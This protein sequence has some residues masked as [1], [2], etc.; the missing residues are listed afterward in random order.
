MK[1]IILLLSLLIYFSCFAL[2]ST[3]FAISDLQYD[4]SLNWQVLESP[5]FSVYFPQNRNTTPDLEPIA[6]NIAEIAEEIRTKVANQLGISKHHHFQKTAIIIEDFSDY[7]QGF[8]STFPHRVIR[9]SLTAPNAKS[10]DMKFKSWLKMVIAHEYTHIAHYEM[11]GG[12]TRPLRA[13]FGQI[14]TPN[15][16]QPIWSIEGL[17]VYNETSFSSGGRGVDTRYDMY[18]RMDSLENDFLS[19]D[20]ISGYYLKSWPSGT[21][22]YIYGQSLIH[23]ISENYGEDKIIKLSENFIR[24]PLLG[25]NHATKKT[26]NIDLNELYQRWKDDLQIKFAKQKEKII[27]SG[28]ITKSRQLT[29]YSY[30]VDYPQWF[31]SQAKD[32][33]IFRASTPH[34]YP[35]IQTIDP[36]RDFAPL[37]RSVIEN[38]SL[39]KRTYGRGSS[40]DISNNFPNY[41]VYSKINNDNRYYEFFDLYLYQFNTGEEFQL[42]KGLRARDPVFSPSFN[43]KGKGGQMAAIIN[44][45]GTNNLILVDLDLPQILNRKTRKIEKTDSNNI[46]YLT[47]FEDGTQLYE[48]SWSPDGKIIALS[49]WK[50]GALDIY[51]LNLDLCA[52]FT[53][54]FSTFAIFHDRYNDLSPSWS[55]D[56]EYLF[57]SSDRTGIYNIFA[58][59][60]SNRKLYQVTNVLGGA[61][62][63]SPSPDNKQLAYIEYHATGYELHLMEIN[64]NLW[65]EIKYDSYQPNQSNQNFKKK[66]GLPLIK[67]PVDSYHALSSLWPP[68]YWIPAVQISNNSFNLGFSTELKDVLGI[69]SIPFMFTYDIFNRNFNYSLNYYSYE[70]NP[71]VHFYWSGKTSALPQESISTHSQISLWD[72][73]ITGFNVNFLSRGNTQLTKHSRSYRQKFSLGYQYEKLPDNHSFDFNTIPNSGPDNN[74]KDNIASLRLKYTYSD[75]EKYSFSVSPEYGQAFSINYEH[76]DPA[77]GG[78]YAFDKLL[79]DGRKYISLKP[80]HHVLAL[81]LVAGQ[82]SNNILEKEKFNLGGHV[83]GDQFANIDL[84]SYSLRGYSP[85]FIKGSH[86]LFASMEYRFPITTIERGLKTGP[87]FLFL[88]KISGLLFFDIG[89]VWD[90]ASSLNISE[91]NAL[92]NHWSDF[93]SGIGL[94]LKAEFNQKFEFPF[95]LRFGAAKALSSS[96]GYDI[97]FSLDSSF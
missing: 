11:T 45:S 40:Y 17:A 50:N 9:L 27:A 52:N 3:S 39:I 5:H 33:I 1:K 8:A 61:F 19:L 34:S 77:L 22:P 58:F 38:K 43:E 51:T 53:K 65:K 21:A 25:M 47:Q 54:D 26:L 72:E 42:S 31:S 60:L 90:S 69:Y 92:N 41:L 29:Q 76:A 32:K 81:R 95:T 24:N 97:Y 55:S 85:S 44:E 70:H 66:K 14:L 88:E 71:I 94:E 91:N 64:V 12:Y 78:N 46:F 7:T 56:G 63:P 6:Q 86:L 18:L 28:P 49:A 82:S 2:F 57:F 13:L 16:L 80:L 62:E 23:F 36:S 89:N 15:A 48:P 83:S 20:Q 68:A 35:F 93:K 37:T 10:F 96:E 73:G 84:N 74:Q 30:W 4:P 87:L 59:S 67:Y 75:I 79:F